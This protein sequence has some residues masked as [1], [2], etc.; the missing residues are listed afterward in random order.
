MIRIV[1]DVKGYEDG[2]LVL[3]AQFNQAAKEGMKTVMTRHLQ[4]VRDKSPSCPIGNTHNLYDAHRIE[5][6]KLGSAIIGIVR[7]AG[8]PY[9]AAVHAGVTS[10]GVIRKWS[11][12]GSGPNWMGSKVLKYNNDYARIVVRE[13]QTSLGSAIGASVR[14]KLSASFSKLK[15]LFRR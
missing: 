6:D 2:M 4:D 12:P 8:I 7:V 1:T 10:R 5:I 14:N 3:K 15:G 13:L 11:R 9:A